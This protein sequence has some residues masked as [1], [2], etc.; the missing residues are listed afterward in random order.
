MT[1]DTSTITLNDGRAMPR[2]GFGVWQ[3]PNDETAKAVKEAVA[4]GYRL[5]DTA[6]V[7]GNEQGVGKAIREVEAPRESLFI[8][9]KLWNDS[10]GFDA[11]LRAFDRSMGLLGL[12]KLDLY[13]IHWPAP[14]LDAYVDS[15]RALIRLR[16]EGRVASIGVSNFNAQQIQRLAGETGVFPAVNQ[17]ELHPFFQQRALHEF[18]GAHDIVTEAWSPLGKGRI[19][20]ERT[21]IA[22]AAKHG[23]SPAQIVLRWHLENGIVAIPKSITPARIRANFDLAGFE[24]DDE[25]KARMASLDSPAGR[26]G[27]DPAHF[28][29]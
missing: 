6:A 28:P 5:I 21:L 15:W 25:D 12:E 29:G 16:E 9:T 26:V 2:Q 27:P 22:I 4:A 18:H 11:A 17:V 24:L 23:K 20:Q 7:Y 19:L 14:R 3:I 13:L 1:P 8:T 10:H